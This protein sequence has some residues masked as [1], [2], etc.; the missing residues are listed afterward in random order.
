MRRCKYSYTNEKS[1]IT[2]QYFQLM[3]L[4]YCYLSQYLKMRGRLLLVD[5]G[6]RLKL[7]VCVRIVY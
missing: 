7:Q 5:S 1:K 6:I 3:R 2:M 4:N